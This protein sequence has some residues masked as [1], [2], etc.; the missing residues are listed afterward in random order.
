VGR[1]PQQRLPTE[2]EIEQ[3][4]RDI[5]ADN[6]ELDRNRPT[7][8]FLRQSGGIQWTRT[9]PNTGERELTPIASELQGM[10]ISQR[11]LLGIVRRDGMADV[12]NIVASEFADGGT[13]RLR[14]DDTGTYLDR[15]ALIE[16]IVQEAGGRPAYRTAEAEAAAARLADLED[17]FERIARWTQGEV[18]EGV[19]EM[20][21][22]GPFILRSGR[23]GRAGAR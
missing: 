3:A 20:D 10:G 5:I 13:P 18:A 4:R 21:S 7:M 15:D 23:R 14:T 1:L 19:E 12:D 17:N 2:E 16:A 11:Q 22:H 8:D 9:N 6:P